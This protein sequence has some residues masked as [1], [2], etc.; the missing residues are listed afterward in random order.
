MTEITTASR[1]GTGFAAALVL[2]ALLLAQQPA[3]PEKVAAG[4]QSFQESQ[5]KLRQFE[6]IETTAVSYK[7][8]VKSKKQNRCYYGADG[9]LQ[10]VPVETREQAKIQRL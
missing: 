9:V 3:P 7:G 5:A 2:P 6:W 4:K 1:I 8:E 10:K